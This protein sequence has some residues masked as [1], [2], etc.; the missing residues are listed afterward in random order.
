MSGEAIRADWDVLQHGDSAHDF[1]EGPNLSAAIAGEMGGNLI[2]VVD[3]LP[4]HAD[5]VEGVL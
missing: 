1:V 5:E 2:G 4:T 3:D